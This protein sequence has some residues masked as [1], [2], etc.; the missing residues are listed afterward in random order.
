MRRHLLIN[1]YSRGVFETHTCNFYDN[2]NITGFSRQI[3]QR[4]V[5]IGPPV[6]A[7]QQILGVLRKIFRGDG[8]YFHWQS[9]KLVRYEN[10]FV[11]S[12]VALHIVC[13]I[14]YL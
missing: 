3:V 7:L 4:T 10:I 2:N 11:L 14:V 6:F 5:Q 13:F 8:A 9:N 12:F 1:N